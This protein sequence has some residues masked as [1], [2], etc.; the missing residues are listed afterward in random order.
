MRTMFQLPGQLCH[1]LD[2]QIQHGFIFEILNHIFRFLIYVC[3]HQFD[4]LDGVCVPDCLWWIL[5]SVLGD[6]APLQLG[7][8]MTRWGIWWQ[9]PLG[10]AEPW[11][12]D[13]GW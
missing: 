12:R 4:F 6:F 7:G 11:G 3:G 1:L 8:G 9:L 13:R 5:D 2:F 10:P